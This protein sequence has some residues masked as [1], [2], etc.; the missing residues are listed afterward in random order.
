MYTEN[1]KGENS[2]TLFHSV[3]FRPGFRRLSFKIVLWL[4]YPLLTQTHL[5]ELIKG[6]EWVLVSI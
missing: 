6:R 5:L 4:I 2:A 3:I 1:L